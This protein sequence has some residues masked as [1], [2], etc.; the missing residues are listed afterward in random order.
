MTTLYPAATTSSAKS[1]TSG[2]MPGSSWMT[3]TP[4]PEP[5]R[6]KACVVPSAANWSFVHPSSV[7][8]SRSSQHLLVSGLDW[9]NAAQSMGMHPTVGMRGMAL[10]VLTE[11]CKSEVELAAS[12]AV[13]T[14]K[15]VGG[16]SLRSSVI[17]TL[18]TRPQHCRKSRPPALMDSVA[19]HRLASADMVE[20]APPASQIARQWVWHRASISV[21]ARTY[22]GQ[23]PRSHVCRRSLTRQRSTVLPAR[24][25]G[26][27]SSSAYQRLGWGAE[28]ARSRCGADRRLPLDSPGSFGAPC[29]AI[30]DRLTCLGTKRSLRH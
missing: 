16:R 14:A 2:V 3:T 24:R 1:I 23:P 28:A 15:F 20:A 12:L 21:H 4:G 27:W 17:S 29:V 8:T 18:L 7:T 5:R 13:K 6:Q 10:R 26:G 19:V 22:S 25:F 30:A 9:D 11:E